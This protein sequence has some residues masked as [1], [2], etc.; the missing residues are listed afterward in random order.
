MTRT[1]SGNSQ[2]VNKNKHFSKPIHN[3]RDNS[4]I[5][6]TQVYVL[7]RARQIEL[8]KAGA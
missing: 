4:L 5:I 2:Q 7:R 6:Q 3:L 1:S 8:L